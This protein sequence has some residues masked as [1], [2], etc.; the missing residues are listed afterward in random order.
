MEGARRAGGSVVQVNAF[1]GP[2]LAYEDDLIT[3]QILKFGA[4]TRPELA[5][6]LNVIAPGDHIFDVGA[7]IGTFT[8]PI[9]KRV[10]AE[11]MVLAVEALP[12]TYRILRK[13]LRMNALQNTVTAVNALIAPPQVAYVAVRKAH[14][15]GGTRFEAANT[16]LPLP[17]TTIDELVAAHFGPRV[18]KIDIEGFETFALTNSDIVRN[19]KPILYAEVSAASL[20]RNG[21]SIAELNAFLSELGYLFFRNARPRN[22]N[23]DSFAV[24][25]LLSL[26]DGGEFFDVLAIHRDDERRNWLVTDEPPGKPN[27]GA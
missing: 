7:H 10:G 6:L 8:I 4:H 23:N 16:G 24:E 11:G 2:L 17:C 19:H 15:T 14:N 18:I 21:S 13:N 3:N 5:M 22:A 1:F 12:R 26:Q 27:T 25:R 20:G 9:A